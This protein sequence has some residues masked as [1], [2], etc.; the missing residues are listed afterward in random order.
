MTPR[1]WIALA[2]AGSAVLLLAAFGFQHLGGFLPCAMCL[3]Q[4]WPHVA[5]IALSVLGYARPHPIFAWAGAA[6]MVGNAGL[7]VF[8]TGVER[9]WWDGPSTCAGSA[10]QDLGRLD[11]DALLDFSTGPQIVL[12]DTAA[13]HILGLSMASWNAIGC[14]L[15]AVFWIAAARRPGPV[16]VRA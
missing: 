8:H 16:V 2:G 13:L 9:D 12:C 5:A 4:R 1:V 6:T 11:A 14:A 15:L 10:A 3:W 7:G